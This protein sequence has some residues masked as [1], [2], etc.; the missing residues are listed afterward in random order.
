M[1]AIRS[2]YDQESVVERGDGYDYALL[3]YRDNVK[4]IGE[5][6]DTTIIDSDQDAHRILITGQGCEVKGFTIRNSGNL[7]SG[8]YMYNA[9]NCKVSG[10]IV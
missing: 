3:I 2:Y 8:V 1:Y 5:A 7:Y 4:L 10:N 9:S 6:R